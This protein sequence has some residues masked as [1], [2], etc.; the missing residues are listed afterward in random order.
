ML[1][2]DLNLSFYVDTKVHADIPEKT[3]K[4]APGITAV[5]DK[6][7]HNRYSYIEMDRVSLTG[8]NY[9]V[10][11]YIHNDKFEKTISSSK[12]LTELK[13]FRQFF[14]SNQEIINKVC[15]A[16][17]FLFELGIEH[18]ITETDHSEEIR[19]YQGWYYFKIDNVSL[20]HPAVFMI[21]KFSKFLESRNIHYLSD[22]DTANAF[23]FFQTLSTEAIKNCFTAVI[24]MNLINN[25]IDQKTND[26]KES[27]YTE[28]SNDWMLSIPKIE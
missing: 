19:K 21:D 27:L 18:E 7:N 4:L 28:N 22:Y 10:T 1:S 6:D 13:I 16:Y 14:D 3:K 9:R 24:S 17:Q 8:N 26:L 15:G 2:P 23:I 11:V 5:I 12:Y 20:M 25:L